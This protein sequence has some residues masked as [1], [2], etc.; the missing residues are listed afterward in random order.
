MMTK[1][2]IP[3]QITIPGCV[4]KN[5]LNICGT[6]YSSIPVSHIGQEADCGNGHSVKDENVETVAVLELPF[7]GDQRVVLS[8][9]LV[10]V[11][12]L[13]QWGRRSGEYVV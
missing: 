13:D 11:L 5:L 9:D 1:I 4:L 2:H 7:C 8:L 3:T 6:T 12:E 10:Q